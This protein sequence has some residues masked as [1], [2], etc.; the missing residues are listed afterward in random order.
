[1]DGHGNSV[2][3]GTG[4]DATVVAGRRVYGVRVAEM[5]PPRRVVL[6]IAVDGRFQWTFDAPGW[7]PISVGSG[8]SG[9]YLW[10]ARE[11]IGLPEEASGQPRLV[12]GVDEDLLTPFSDAYGWI[13]VCETSVRRVHGGRETSRLELDAVVQSSFW[14]AEDV[15]VVRGDDGAECRV[16]IRGTELRV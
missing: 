10:T 6:T 8:A 13:L 11:V 5:D 12:L 1:M 2:I 4:V 7:R 15:L 14:A 3:A 16:T 9:A